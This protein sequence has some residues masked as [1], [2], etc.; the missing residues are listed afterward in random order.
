MTLVR[1]RKVVANRFSHVTLADTLK[2]EKS[3]VV[4]SWFSSSGYRGVVSWIV[5]AYACREHNNAKN[6]WLVAAG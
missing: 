5:E 1:G 2:N 6:A 4:L 3:S